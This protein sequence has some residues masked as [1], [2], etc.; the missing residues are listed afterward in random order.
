MM[1]CA[2]LGYMKMMEC[3]L[4]GYMLTIHTNMHACKGRSEPVCVTQKNE[5]HAYL[6]TCMHTYVYAY[7]HA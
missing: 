4:L 1:G 5:K 3:A 7:A 2:L 6:R